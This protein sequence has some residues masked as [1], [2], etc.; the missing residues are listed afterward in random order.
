MGDER[1]TPLTENGLEVNLKS[2]ANTCEILT[3]IVVVY[4]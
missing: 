3:K 2:L 4:I 1:W